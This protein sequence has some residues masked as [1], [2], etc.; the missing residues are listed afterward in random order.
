[1]KHDSLSSEKIAEALSYLYYDDREEWYIAAFAIKSELGESGFDI[2]L[3]W[4][5]GY[6]GF[7]IADAN[8][9]WRSTG[10]GKV[11]IGT[12]IHMAMQ[13]GFKLGESQPLSKHAL[14]QRAENRRIAQENAEVKEKRKK[15][16]Q[17]KKAIT[18][19]N[20]FDSLEPVFTHPYL[21][22][23]DILAHGV[24]SG[25]WT[26]KL[27][28]GSL[29]TEKNALI[30]PMYADGEIVSLQAIMPCGA[31]HFMA[32]AQKSGTYFRFGD[33]QDSSFSGEVILCEGFATGATIQEG[34]QCLTFAAFD[35]GNLLNV[36]KFLREKYPFARIT[37]AADNDQ[38]KRKNAGVA[39][40]QKVACEIDAD[41]ILP[42]FKDLRGNPTDFNDL[43]M[44]E[45]YSPIT[46]L[47]CDKARLYTA[48]PKSGILKLSAFDLEYI[49]DAEKVFNESDS[50]ILVARA[51]LV[52]AMRLS[53]EVPA[54]MTLEQI[55]AY[56][57]HPL[58]SP[59]THLSIMCRVQWSIFSRKRIALSA[60][61]PERWSNKH[62]YVCVHDLNEFTPT[63]PVTL[64]SA[65]MGSGKTKKVIKPF[66][67]RS[68]LFMAIAHRRSL[69]S[70]L[71]KEL[72][73][74]SYDDVKTQEQGD[75]VE[76]MAI[77]LPSTQA[78]VYSRF[79]HEM[80]A[81]A[82]DE[83]SQNIRFTSSKECRVAG[84]GQDAIF[85]GLQRIISCA[86]QVIACDASIDQTT[87]TFFEK[88]R[89]DERFTIVEQ[90]PTNT[91]RSCF[92]Y[93]DRADF[94]AKI[95][96]ELQS[97]GKVWLAVE[98]AE[99][100]EV[101]SEIY[102]NKF[103]SITITARNS[104]TKKIKDF[105]DNIEEES[106][107]YDIVIASP[108]ISSGVS[109]EH[110][111]GHHFTM[112]AGM[113]SGHSICFSDFAQMLGRVRYVKD[114]HI[115]LQKNNKR[116]E[117]VNAQSIINGLRQAANIEGEQYRE[118][119]YSHFKAHI[120]VTEEVYRSDFANGLVWFLEY[121]CFEI[122][123]GGMSSGDYSLSELMKEVSGEAKKKYREDIISAKKISKE[124][125]DVLGQMQ[126]LDD[127][128][129]FQ[130]LAFKLRMSFNFPIS[131]EITEQDIDFFESM[132]TVD[133]FAAYMGLSHGKDEFDLNISLRRFEKARIKA[134]EIIFKDIDLTKITSS[135]CDRMIK[136]VSANENRFLLASLKLVP[137]AYGQWLEDKKGKLK[138][139]PIPSK[140]AKP[141]AAILEK[142]GLSW[143]RSSQ[144]VDG[145]VVNCY[146]VNQ[147]KMDLVKYYA[148]QRFK[149]KEEL[150]QN[151]I[152]IENPEVTAIRKRIMGR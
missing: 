49:E 40:A 23:K 63:N 62:D 51:A 114:Y 30:I 52:M 2:W 3:N 126:S 92:L 125:A 61:K 112:I 119:S 83:I 60:I 106:K 74:E 32:G 97:G 93:D 66:S 19:R 10:Y 73:I 118:T 137:S 11:T 84:A 122:K 58:L 54:F 12:L 21:E 113:A 134:C 9:V 147:D 120:D 46:H 105:L 129:F 20:I 81:V 88:S 80:P 103:N 101:L 90:P 148:E 75:Y 64:V 139:Y 150:V 34:T 117:F 1:M 115:F 4:S 152:E 65:P 98:S 132:P 39:A 70:D 5:K 91:D 85:S 133:R 146:K 29:Y 144:R 41:I 27:E 6:E 35:A 82:I 36:G 57:D 130:L 28:D 128:Q 8:A 149:K 107:K 102:G 109:V 127:E 72:G 50:E 24:K 143:S 17:F 18:A 43:Y 141:V 87:L 95:D 123:K 138:G 89:P 55:R 59:E 14:K 145:K 124:R 110:R 76:K 68:K 38:Y 140:T 151:E 111:D 26:Y 33:D 15:E 77:C 94:L 86:D 79:V 135:D 116:N 78:S 13:R 7:K 48:K 99:K 71:S 121:F 69:I 45:G 108:A 96:E 25:E 104:K 142:F 53:K 37:I 47:V 44:Q 56:L 131:H 136:R 22:K 16:N 31:K 42:I 100:A 67:Q